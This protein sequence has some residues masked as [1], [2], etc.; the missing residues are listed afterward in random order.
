MKNSRFLALGAILL[1]AT[2][3]GCGE[4]GGFSAQFTGKLLDFP[5]KAPVPGG[6]VEAVYNDTGEP[7]PGQVATAAEDGTV[8]FNFENLSGDG[9]VG[10]KAVGVEGESKDTYLFN[11][12]A[13]EQDKKIYLITEVT[14]QFSMDMAEVDWD[15]TTGVAAGSVYW[16][17]GP[18]LGQ[19]E[20]VGCA[21]VETDPPSGDVRYFSN[22]GFPTTLANRDTTNPYNAY[23]LFTNIDPGPVKVRASVDGTEIGS[24]EFLSIADSIC[25]SDITMNPPA[26]PQPADCE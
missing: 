1:I 5:S 21:T 13:N 8:A 19:G 6:K 12:D 14:V 26:N 9:L 25:I 22:T 23:Y 4:D 2:L 24:S 17:D 7:I 18:I 20:E 11:V 10:F 3:A 15:R 16:F